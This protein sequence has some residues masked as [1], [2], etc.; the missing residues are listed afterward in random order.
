MKL[1]SRATNLYVILLA[2][3]KNN[4]NIVVVVVFQINSAK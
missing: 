3:L 2:Q 1:K 4:A